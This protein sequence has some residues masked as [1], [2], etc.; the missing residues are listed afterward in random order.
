VSGELALAVTLILVALALAAGTLILR[1]VLIS[2]RGGVVECALRRSPAAPWRHGLAEYQRG[3]LSWY[4]SLSFRLRPGVVFDRAE[5]RILG[6]RTS[7]IAEAA[8]LGP[9]VIIA[10]CSTSSA[11]AAAGG[12]RTIELAMAEAAFTGLLAWLESSPEFRTRA[13]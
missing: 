13:S 12:R 7:T 5:L 9:G 1:Q 2:R 4:R 3:Q 6:T 10:E 11:Q 8:S